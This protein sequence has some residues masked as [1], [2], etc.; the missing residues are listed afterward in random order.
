MNPRNAVAVAAEEARLYGEAARLTEEFCA[1]IRRG[2]DDGG[3]AFNRERE[4]IL[5][6]IRSLG[7]PPEVWPCDPDELEQ[8]WSESAR[9]IQRI[10]DLDRELLGLLEA[11]KERVSHELAQI[12]RGRR[13]LASYRGPAAISPAF[14]DRLS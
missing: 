4:E 1:R 3:E 6:R 7:A 12:R 13:T 14:V 2:D 8:H 5:N 10:L 9:A 11:Q